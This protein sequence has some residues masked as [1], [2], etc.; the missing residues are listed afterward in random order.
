MVGSSLRTQCSVVIVFFYFG[1]RVFVRNF[2]I[3]WSCGATPCGVIVLPRNVISVT[4]K[5]H[6]LMVS[7]SPAFRMHSKTA[8]MLRISCVTLL[9]AIPI[10]STYCAHW[11]ALITLSRYSRTKLENAESALL[12]P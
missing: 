2:W 10:S 5:W 9:T 11:S 1:N 6:F 8:R 7:L 12:N 4:P 3:L